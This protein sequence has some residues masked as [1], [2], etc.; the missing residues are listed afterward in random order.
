MPSL[1]ARVAAFKARSRFAGKKY[2]QRL[3]RAVTRRPKGRRAMSL[4]KYNVHM[5]RR[6]ASPLSFVMSSSSTALNNVITFDLSQVRNPG[7]LT[8]LYDQYMITGVKVIFQLCNNPD[9]R[10]QLLTTSITNATNV[11][12]RLFYSRDYDNSS[13]ETTNDLRE[14]NTTKSVILR[15][16][17]SHSVFLKPAIRNQVYL[18]GI[19]T[20]TSPV[21]KQ[22]LDCSVNNVPHYGLKFSLELLGFTAPQDYHLRVET[23]YYLKFK[24]AR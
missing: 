5:Y 20:A 2:A 8:N 24:N 14:R 22:W 16:N 19:T 15:P 1:R 3:R 10:N 18:D 6:Y 4:Q 7:E 12:P 13:V 17:S 23:L 21:W 11:Y 9:A